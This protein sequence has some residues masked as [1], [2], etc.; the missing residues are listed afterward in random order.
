MGGMATGGCVTGVNTTGDSKDVVFE[1]CGCWR[2]MEGV[3]RSTLA[4]TN[5][6]QGRF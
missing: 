1:S 6:S 3:T 4:Q 5:P 2:A